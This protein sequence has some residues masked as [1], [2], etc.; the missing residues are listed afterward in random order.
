MRISKQITILIIQFFFYVVCFAQR[1]KI[2]SL[3]KIL[4]TAKGIER[5][6]CLNTLSAYNYNQPDTALLYA[7]QAFHEA[8]SLHYVQGMGDAMFN[9]GKRERNCSAVVQNYLRVIA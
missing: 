8:E 9:E 4:L 7:S 6:N 5:V 3:K 2:D 1:E